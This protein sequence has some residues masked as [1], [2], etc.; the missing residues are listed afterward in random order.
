VYVPLLYMSVEF[1]C[2]THLYVCLYC[3]CQWSLV[4]GHVCICAFIGHVSEV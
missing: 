4:A 1:S 3:T 2:W